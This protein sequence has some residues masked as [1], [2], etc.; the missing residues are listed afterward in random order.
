MIVPK[1]IA[2]IFATYGV[3]KSP[4]TIQSWAR[5]PG[6]SLPCRRIGRLILIH[7]DDLDRWFESHGNNGGT[8]P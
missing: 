2:Y 6:H 7:R 1:V 3:R 4:R 8:R 5:Q